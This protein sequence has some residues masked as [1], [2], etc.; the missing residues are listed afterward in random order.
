MKRLITKSINIHLPDNT[1][2]LTKGDCLIVDSLEYMIDVVK[3]IIKDNRVIHINYMSHK[4]ISITDEE[5]RKVLS[6]M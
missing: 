4:R 1:P 5:Y 3:V 6:N 2:D